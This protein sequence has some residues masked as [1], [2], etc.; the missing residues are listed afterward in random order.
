MKI[1]KNMIFLTA[2]LML[3]TACGVQLKK[4]IP[5]ADLSGPQDADLTRAVNCGAT[6]GA[7]VAL[8]LADDALRK[9]PA[10]SIILTRDSVE[11]DLCSRLRLN[12]KQ[13]AIIQFASV[14]CYAC[15]RWIDLID[16]E[17]V[18]GGYTDIAHVVI[19]S[20]NILALNER[21]AKRI[22]DEMAP[23]ADWGMDYSGAAWRFFTPGFD[24]TDDVMPTVIMMDMEARGFLVTDPKLKLADLLELSNV[25]LGIKPLPVE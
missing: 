10:E 2:V 15:Q 16:T 11:N 23:N 20:D 21:G 3:V 14:E 19:F 6:T 9:V 22:I 12:G 5:D 7:D 8:T 4:K 1:L 17:I 13:L 24:Q 25:N 18:A